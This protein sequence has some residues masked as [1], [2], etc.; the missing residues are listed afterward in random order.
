MAPSHLYRASLAAQLA[1]CSECTPH[2]APSCIRHVNDQT[3][4]RIVYCTPQVG[5][6]AASTNSADSAQTSAIAA[7]M[8]DR[9]AAQSSFTGNSAL[10][11]QLSHKHLE[12][13]G[14]HA[15]LAFAKD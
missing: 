15:L 11:L 1:C 9:I 7:K 4:V 3:T 14:E 8:C 12:L 6:Y 5:A 13:A 2:T 10:L